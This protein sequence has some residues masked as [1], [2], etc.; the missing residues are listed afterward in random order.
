MRWK[1]SRRLS[2]TPHQSKVAAQTFLL[3]GLFFLE[4]P[5]QSISAEVDR[6]RTP[7]IGPVGF[8]GLSSGPYASLPPIDIET[9]HSV[10]RRGLG[11]G[12]PEPETLVRVSGEESGPHIPEPMVFDLIRPLGAKR[13]EAE[14]NVL[15]LVP[16]GRKSKSV[17]DVSDPLGLVRRSPDTQ[18]IEWA[19][20]IEYAVGDGLAVELELPMENQTLEAVKAAGQA[21]FGTKFE[22]RFIHGAQTIVQY[23]LQ[24]RLWNLT[25]LYLAGFR[26]DKTWSVFGMVGP[27]AEVGGRI[28]NQTVEVLS[29]ITVFA[30][31]TDRLVGGIETNVGQVLDGSTALLVM[32]QLA[33]E[34]DKHWMIQTGIG[35]RA[36]PGLTL[37]EVGFRIISEF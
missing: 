24:P 30:D 29:N 17:N 14:V 1:F 7:F 22:N 31:L 37:P 6:R 32:P 16:L 28:D 11:S 5:A 12:E 36:T 9:D 10:V 4:N 26:F 3:L 2:A 21:T 25:F 34:V 35:V 27:R 19:P 13:G 15:G 20:E 23:D 18:G 33:Y 8:A